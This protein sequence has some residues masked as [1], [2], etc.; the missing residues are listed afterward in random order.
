MIRAGIGRVRVNGRPIELV[1]PEAARYVMLTPLI[2]S[3][4]L[5]NLVD[6]D[7]KASG[8]GF[9]GQAE[10][11]AMAISKS[12]VKWFAAYKPNPNPNIDLKKRIVS[13]NKV[14]L[15]GDPRQKEPKKAGRVGARRRPQKSYR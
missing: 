1:E 3:G 10:A 2:L 14:L 6:I 8:G 5:R 4:E 13:Y 7:I 11:A 15:V 12:M 9:M